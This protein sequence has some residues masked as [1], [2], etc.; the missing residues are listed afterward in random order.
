[1]ER[2]LYEENYIKTQIAERSVC[3]T[4]QS[5][6]LCQDCDGLGTS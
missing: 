6:T 5:A 2:K 4:A 1:M 3:W